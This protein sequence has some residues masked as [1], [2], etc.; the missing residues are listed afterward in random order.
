[1]KIRFIHMRLHKENAITKHIEDKMYLYEIAERKKS[2]HHKHFEGTC[3][4]QLQQNRNLK[5]TKE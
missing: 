1:L 4:C 5:M 2:T 3:F